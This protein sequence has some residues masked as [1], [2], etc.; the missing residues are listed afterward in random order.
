MSTVIPGMRNVTQVE[1]NVAA[2]DLSDLPEMLLTSLRKHIWLRG[3]WHAG[4]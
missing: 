4:K 3:N 1:A 2:S